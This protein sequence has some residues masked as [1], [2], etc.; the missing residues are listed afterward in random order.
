MM[1]WIA[2]VEIYHAAVIQFVFGPPQRDTRPVA[3][4][5]NLSAERAKRRRQSVHPL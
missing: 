5:I 2:W 1:L 3:E 4:V